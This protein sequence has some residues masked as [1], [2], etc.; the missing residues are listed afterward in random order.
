ML[1][2]TT[3]TIVMMMATITEITLVV[4]EYHDD[5]NENEDQSQYNCCH[6]ASAWGAFGIFLT[7]QAHS[8]SGCFTFRVKTLGL[9]QVVAAE[10]F[11]APFL[12]PWHL[13]AS[14][15]TYIVAVLEVA[16]E[17]LRDANLFLCL[18]FRRITSLILRHSLCNDYWLLLWWHHHWLLHWVSRLARLHISLVWIGCDLVLW[19]S[20][21]YWL[22]DHRILLLDLLISK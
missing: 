13:L 17:P 9:T 11:A 4:I 18:N 2:P 1:P 15:F 14:I 20:H 5:R 12:A 7:I 21:H 10:H 19:S 8:G 22:A 3:T 6:V 16:N